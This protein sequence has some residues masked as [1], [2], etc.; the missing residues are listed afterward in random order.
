MLIY[1]EDA[2]FEGCSIASEQIDN[3][4]NTE[5]K[6]R[7]ANPDLVLDE[8]QAACK[9][10]EG[11]KN[12]NEAVR[13]ITRARGVKF[14]NQRKTAAVEKESIM[15]ENTASKKASTSG[16]KTCTDP[17][18]R[19]KGN[20]KKSNKADT[21][22]TRSGGANNTDWKRTTTGKRKSNV[23]EKAGS[24]EASTPEKNIKRKLTYVS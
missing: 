10:L 19:L 15:E 4:T 24:K 14:T 3:M 22:R 2:I 9:I 13:N 17:S 12:S 21:C 23:L 18:R 8:D 1:A 11:P 16:K 7:I 5:A 20:L 6:V